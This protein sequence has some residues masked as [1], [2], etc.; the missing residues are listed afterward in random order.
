MLP[1]SPQR[2]A[3]GLRAD[4]LQSGSARSFTQAGVDTRAL[5]AGSVFVAVQGRVPGERYFGDALKRGAGAL[6]GRGFSVAVR[7]AARLRGAWLFRV[8]EGLRALQDLAADQRRLLDCPVVAITGSNGKT[9]TKD[10]LA[11]LLGGEA[12]SVLATRGNHNNHLGVPLTLLR[13]RPGLRFAV[14]EAGMNHPGELTVLGRI[15]RP[16]LAVEL[17]VGAAHV[18]NFADGRRG[19]ARAKEEL[20]RA[21]GAGGVAVVNQDDPGTA[22]MGRRFNGRKVGFGRSRGAHLRLDRIV[23]RGAAGLEAR[24]RWSAPLGGRRASFGIT[25]RQGGPA[26]ADQAAAGLAAALSLGLEPELLRR[27]LRAWTPGGAM[28]QELRPLAGGATG[29][30]DAYNASPESMRA[31]LAF[32][33]LSAPRARRVAVLGCMLE[34]G[35]DAHRLHRALGAAARSAG[36]RAL[37]VLGAQADA[38]ASAFGAGARAFA[39]A[40]AREA[41][42]W[43]RPR[44]GAGDWC[45]FKGSR[46]L[47][48]ERVYELLAPNPRGA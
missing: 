16:D 12:A 2:L 46:G 36:V 5:E 21:M 24:A 45:L 40:Q 19:I 31:A 18:G 38:V 34:L 20:L 17:N 26:R 1:F 23:D 30:L 47:A 32:L 33:S 10:L 11:H 43:V 13:A 7:R 29:I 28:R 25:L 8:R 15:I 42:D 41:A 44:L 39:A 27:R 22:A 35:P 48:V 6:V 37:A 9:S 4:I 3:A 14:L